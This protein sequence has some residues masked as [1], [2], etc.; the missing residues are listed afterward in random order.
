MN[1]G[2][3]WPA[4]NVS[5]THIRT[6]K[7]TRMFQGGERDGFYHVRD[8]KVDILLLEWFMRAVL[9]WGIWT[10]TANNFNFKGWLQPGVLFS[11]FGCS[12][13]DIVNTSFS[14][15]PW[16][17]NVETFW[18]C[19]KVKQVLIDDT[20]TLF[21]LISLTWLFTL[22]WLNGLLVEIVD[23]YLLELDLGCIG[24]THFVKSDPTGTR[25]CQFGDIVWDCIGWICWIL[26][27]VT[28]KLVIADSGVGCW[29]NWFSKVGDLNTKLIRYWC[30]YCLVVGA[31]DKFGQIITSCYNC[32]GQHFSWG[33]S[34]WWTGILEFSG[35]TQSLRLQCEGDISISDG[36]LSC[37]WTRCIIKWVFVPN[38]PC[39]V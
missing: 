34:M 16:Y 13:V 7:H 2:V 35:E 17:A 31:C 18:M 11:L 33:G 38:L 10:E 3:F 6:A 32:W 5:L 20:M 8:F 1:H 28:R 21:T 15:V 19:G 30:I 25:N 37:S 23:M 4:L 24:Y 26:W 39:T 29:A 27:D 12:Y 14:L 22:A 9:W 36:R